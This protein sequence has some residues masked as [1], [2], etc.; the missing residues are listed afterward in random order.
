MI[1]RLGFLH[2]LASVVLVIGSRKEVRAVFVPEQ[3]M[4]FHTRPPVADSVL[5]VT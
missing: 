3:I 4:H 5:R 1:L 2:G